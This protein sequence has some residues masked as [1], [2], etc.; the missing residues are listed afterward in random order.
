[1]GFANYELKASP[2]DK[3]RMRQAKQ[4]ARSTIKRAWRGEMRAK[5]TPAEAALADAL[6]P[7]GV[8][9][10][11]QAIVHGFIPDFWCAKHKLI[12]EVDGLVH[13]LAGQ[14]EYDKKRD[15]ILRAKGITILRFS[16]DEVLND[17]SRC[18][19]QIEAHL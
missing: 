7:L 14:K 5:P 15:G 3:G 10:T 17:A 12:V 9:F 13:S 19:T 2:A 11:R 8:K 1:M 18:V 4:Q 16:N 6:K